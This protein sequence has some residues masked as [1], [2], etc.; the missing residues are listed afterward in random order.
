MLCCTMLYLQLAAKTTE[1]LMHIPI[2]VL[3]EMFH[4]VSLNHNCIKIIFLH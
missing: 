4:T 3:V 1:L 2:K